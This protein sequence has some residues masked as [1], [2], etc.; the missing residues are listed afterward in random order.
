MSLLSHKTWSVKALKCKNSSQYCA[1]LYLLTNSNIEVNFSTTPGISACHTISLTFAGH[2]SN[3]SPSR[4]IHT[5]TF[6]FRLILGLRDIITQQLRHGSWSAFY[7]RSNSIC[8][9]H[10]DILIIF[11]FLYLSW[12][13]MPQATSRSS[14]VRFWG[15]TPI[16]QM[17][18]SL[19]EV[20]VRCFR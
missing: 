19:N 1:M 11:K 15:I 10:P 6:I 12:W 18:R 2:F 17:H 4:E 5:A 14:W 20:T 16:Y 9:I 7:Q 8:V 13:R 3:G